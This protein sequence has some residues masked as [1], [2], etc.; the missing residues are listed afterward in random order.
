[1]SDRSSSP[2]NGG[3]KDERDDDREAERQRGKATDRDK[4]TERPLRG[5]DRRDDSIKSL[6]V[7]GLA[8]GTR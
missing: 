1:M 7:R 8:Q 6:F 2:A 5:R 4:E 3:V